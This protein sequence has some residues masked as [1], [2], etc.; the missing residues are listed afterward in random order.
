MDK[1]INPNQQGREAAARGTTLAEAV[2]KVAAFPLE[3]MAS[4][5]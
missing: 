5:E 1:G 4:D 3:K 2:E